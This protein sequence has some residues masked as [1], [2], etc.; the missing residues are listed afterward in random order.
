M[1][2]YSH[3]RSGTNYLR[4]LLEEALTGKRTTETVPTGHWSNRYM[5][6]APARYFRGGHQFYSPKL[7]GPR[8]YLYRDGRD[9]ALSMW[10]TKR[11]QAR[12]DRGRSFSEYLRQPLDWYE[13]PGKRNATGLT[14]AEHWR[15]HLDSWRKRPA[16]FVRYADLLTDAR[17]ELERIARYVDAPLVCV[18]AEL[19]GQG[20]DPSGDY[21]AGKWRDAFTADDL[22]YFHSIVPQGYWGLDD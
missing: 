8:I 11:F 22:A 13:T 19:D 5:H 2:L 10:R 12:E 4:A 21:R 17:C 20:P 6:Q 15:L 3:P 16:C 14:I 9:V 7:P 18:P 1:K